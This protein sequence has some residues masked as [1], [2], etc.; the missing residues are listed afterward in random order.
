MQHVDA[1]AIFAK[2]GELGSVS[3]AARSLGIPKASVSRTVSRLEA[4]YGVL[5]FDRSDR[6]LRLTEVGRAFHQR[7]LRILDELFE[8]EA[9]I[10]AH[11]GLPA[12]TLRVG[13]SAAVARV[14]LGS[15]SEFLD[16][17][18]EIDLRLRVADRPLPAPHSLDVVIHAGWLS[19]SRL[20]VRK[21][22]GLDMSL[23]ASR[24]YVGRHGLPDEL[25]DLETHRVLGN[26]HPDIVSVEPGLL[27]TR[28]PMLEISRG[29]QRFL[30]PTSKRF[31]SNDHHAL[32]SLVREG[33]AIAPVATMAI[34]SE[35][36]SDD[37]VRVMPSWEV[38]DPPGIYA[39]YT[40]RGAMT[41]KLKV[42]LDFVTNLIRRQKTSTST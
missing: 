9:Q 5:L 20:I 16:L 30:V 26:S 22:S 13:C 21:L 38:H 40:E 17:H 42:F 18:P 36:R 33:Y 7:C 28:V 8:A 41:P 1:F 6:R 31:A 10:A 24:Q 27:P 11:R 14:L 23:V 15:V 4:S 39:L 29:R 2:V 12:G 37:I 32:L 19:D 34:Q 3:G 35:P 25:E